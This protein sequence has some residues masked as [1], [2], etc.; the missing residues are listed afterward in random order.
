M[1]QHTRLLG[2]IKLLNSKT[3]ILSPIRQGMDYKAKAVRSPSLAK[4]KYE[5]ANPSGVKESTGTSSAKKLIHYKK[6]SQ[7]KSKM[8]DK[9]R[10]SMLFDP[11]RT[12][13]YQPMFNIFEKESGKKWVAYL[14]IYR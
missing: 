9:S 10:K 7:P 13:R 3:N 6:R 8:S 11:E 12:K 1:L 5:N 14:Y 4:T 2:N